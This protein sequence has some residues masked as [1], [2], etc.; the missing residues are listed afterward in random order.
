MASNNNDI[1]ASIL[2]ELR[3][4]KQSHASLESRLDGLA[5]SSSASSNHGGSRPSSALATSHGGGSN[6]NTLAQ[7]IPIRNSGNVGG[8]SHSPSNLAGG[9]HHASSAG[10]ATSPTL[11][12]GSPSSPLP[13]FAAN[14]SAAASGLP[15][16]ARRISTDITNTKQ[17]FINWARATPPLNRDRDSAN[18]SD[19]QIYSSRA[20]LTS[21][22]LHSCM[23][24]LMG[25]AL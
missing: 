9:G 15:P 8:T 14:S 25:I 22:W 20:V 18:T 6:N 11:Q 13:S 3:D 4:L 1:L 7:P 21:E 10:G 16:H 17:D 24:L 2:A 23:R 5:I 12:F 19:K